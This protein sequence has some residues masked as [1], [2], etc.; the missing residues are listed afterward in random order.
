[1]RIRM[2]ASSVLALV[3]TLVVLGVQAPEVHEHGGS[4]AALYNEECSLSRLATGPGGAAVPDPTVILP[5]G[6]ATPLVVALAA[7][8]PPARPLLPV[9]ARA[10]PALG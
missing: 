6:P 10:P 2:R 5:H 8:A 7:A 9:S 1:M 3:V 4:S